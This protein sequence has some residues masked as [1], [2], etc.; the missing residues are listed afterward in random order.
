MSQIKFLKGKS[1]RLKDQTLD[2][3]T[4]YFTPDTRRL[5]VDTAFARVPVAGDDM[6]GK[7]F[8]IYLPGGSDNWKD[9]S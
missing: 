3:G 9:E 8:Y 6:L 1:T 4:I 5:Y 7:I 2:N